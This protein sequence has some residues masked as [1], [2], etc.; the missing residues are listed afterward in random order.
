MSFRPGVDT[1]SQLVTQRRR[2]Y[3]HSQCHC[4]QCQ[5]HS[6]A[7]AQVGK[8]LA[9]VLHQHFTAR[10]PPLA[11]TQRCQQIGQLIRLQHW[12]DAALCQFQ[13]TEAFLRISWVGWQSEYGVNQPKHV[14]ILCLV[15]SSSHA[16]VTAG[17]TACPVHV[18]PACVLLLVSR[19][20]LSNDASYVD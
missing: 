5:S 19:S 18:C 4:C 11:Q 17:R 12:L 6:R 8:C 13:L 10:R 3:C 15:G 1:A 14:S 2:H 20:Q 7:L 9:F 16:A